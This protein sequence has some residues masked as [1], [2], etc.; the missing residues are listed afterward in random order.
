[1]SI[2]QSIFGTH[3]NQD[4]YLYSIKNANGVE[5][6]ITNYGATITAIKVPNSNGEIENI[7]CG[8]DTLEGYFSEEYKNNSPYFGGTVGRYCSQIKNASFELNGK[9]YQLE[10]NCGD[11]NLHGGVVGFDKK[12][13]N[14]L[15]IDTE[16][17]K[18]VEMSLLS[19]DME[20]GFPGN[21]N[22]KVTFLLND[23]NELSINY[24]AVPD[25]DTPLSLTNHTYFNL[26][27]FSEGVENHTATVHTNQRL[28]L[29]TTGAATGEIVNVTGKEDD[30]RDGKHIGDVHDLMEDGFEHFYVFDNAKE[31]VKHTASVTFKESGRSLEVFTT[32]PCMLFYTGKYTSDALKRENGEQ[33]GKYRGFCCETH[34]YPNGPNIKNSPKSITKAGEEFNSTTIFKFGW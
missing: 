13:W 18:G 21:V 27:G 24:Y 7:A 23:E 9:V 12:V 14:V 22:V 17:G 10:N 31:I 6:K 2:K 1:M 28:A 30:L 32:E 29:D 8:F 5:V 34:R 15:V 4:I 16:Q 11:N 20:E 26:S 33:Y 3:N 25:A 19:K